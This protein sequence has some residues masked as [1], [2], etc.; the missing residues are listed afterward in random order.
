VPNPGALLG[1]AAIDCVTSGRQDVLVGLVNGD[2][3]S[4][5]LAEILSTPKRLD[6]SLLTLARILAK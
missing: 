6:P 1:A 2:L 5:P 4:T 3:V